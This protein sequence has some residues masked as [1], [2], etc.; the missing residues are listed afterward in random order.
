MVSVVSP[1]PG[2]GTSNSYTFTVG[3]STPAPA[4]TSLSP[5]TAVAGGAAFTLVVNG[6]NFVSSSVVNWSG[7]ALTTTYV[8]A[9]QITA[10]VPAA[11]IASPGTANITVTNPA[12]GGG[13]SGSVAFTIS[14][15]A[16][17]LVMYQNGTR[18][19]TL[20]PAT[21]D[22][23][24]GASP[25]VDYS[26]A[27]NPESGHT[28]SLAIYGNSGWQQ[29][30]IWDTAPYGV[31]LRGYVEL[32]FDVYVPASGNSLIA[33]AHYSRISG[34]DIPTSTGLT[35]TIEASCGTITPGQWNIGKRIRLS[36]LGMLASQAYY[37]F[38]IQTQPGFT[39]QLDNV[40]F[41]AGVQSMLYNNN[42]LTSGWSAAATNG[43]VNLSFVPNSVGSNLF[44]LNQP[45]GTTQTVAEVTAIAV[46]GTSVHSALTFSYAG[47]FSL[48]GLNRF[49]FGALP[50]KSG[51][52]YTVQFYDTSGVAVGNAVNVAA[53]APIDF[54]VNTSNWTVYDFPLSDAGTLPASIGSVKIT[55]TSSNSTN[56]WYITAPGFTS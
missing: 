17:N 45:Q 4:I 54:G 7:A 32:Q 55:E 27:T 30:T 16:G 29:A 44:A 26:Y 22:Y 52:G 43:S 42:A 41:V 10:A 35:T 25:P 21:Y 49:T 40:Q 50:T 13:T 36:H 48:S 53:Y 15:T 34:D 20:W 47:G 39:A 1:S 23:S 9:S 5:S 3:S 6:S 19:L 14:G 24:Y 51:Y 38:L 33:Q 46:T 31:D 28:Q 11:D 12:P 18:N 2:G 37:K 56:E 8:S